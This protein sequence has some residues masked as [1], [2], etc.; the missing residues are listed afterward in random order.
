MRHSDRNDEFRS[1]LSSST[2]ET[3]W[4][5][6]ETEFDPARLHHQETVFTV[7]NGY[8]GTRGA[9]EE[10]HPGAWPATFIHGVFDAVPIAY[11]ELVNCPD[12]LP[13]VILLEGERFRLDLGGEE[14]PLRE[15]EGES[16]GTIATTSC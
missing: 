6:S 2:N 16:Y 3:G 10:G 8:L 7:G 4:T 5:V 12:W 11:T 9:F 13:L 14:E 15:S 1:I